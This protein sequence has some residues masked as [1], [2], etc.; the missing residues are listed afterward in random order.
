MDARTAGVAEELIAHGAEIDPKDSNGNTALSNAIGQGRR[1]AALTLVAY[2][3]DVQSIKAA[4]AANAKNHPRFVAMLSG[5]P[6]AVQAQAR[7]WVA[8]RRLK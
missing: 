3:A 8:Q 7:D 1:A 4:L 2:G 6:A 5:D